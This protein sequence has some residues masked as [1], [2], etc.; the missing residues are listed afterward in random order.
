[1][2]TCLGMYIDKNIIKY[3][4][5]SRDKNHIKIDAFG[6]K[7]YTN[8]KQ[9][10]D[11]IVSETYSF[12]TPISINLSEET[13]NYFSMSNLLNDKDMKRAIKT[14][15]DSYCYDKNINPNALESRYILVNNS[16][17][18]DKI[19]V[20]HVSADKIKINNVLKSF[21][22]QKVSTL[23]PISLGI[24]NISPIKPK[25]NIMVVNIEDKTTVTII[26]GEKVYEVRSIDTGASTILNAINAKENSYSKAYE[27]C[28]NTTIYT[29]QGNGLQEYQNEYLA[30]IIPSLHKIASQVNDIVSNSLVKINKIYITGTASV[31]NNIDLYFEELVS[32]VRCEILKP[33]FIEDTPKV[34]MK[35]YIEVNSAI[36]LA[37]QGLEYGIKGINFTAGKQSNILDGVLSSNTNKSSRGILSKLNSINISDNDVSKIVLKTLTIV[38]VVFIVYLTVSIFTASQINRKE[39]SAKS[40]ADYANSQIALVKKDN[41]SV[42]SKISEYNSLTNKLES[43]TNT[44]TQKNSLKNTIPVLLSEIMRIIPKEVQL[45]SIENPSDK[46]I[47]ITAQSTKYEQLAYF[48]VKIKSEGIL[49]P[50]TVVSSQAVNE[51]DNVK[52]VIEGELP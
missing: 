51:G 36:A 2:A 8:L 14:E 3:A 52:I 30:D 23:V 42:N 29:M 31:I 49:Q 4:K 10:I 34:N 48:K 5:V 40:V 32:G 37:L 24:A 46:R 35:D 13:Y 44:I 17:D 33:F 1:M 6:V 9:A 25:E 41:D 38:L 7:I 21:G 11:Q 50:D 15:F 12:K 27:I 28:K 16:S 45:V 47:L 18:K 43:A 22:D 20:I 19:R 26:E 39:M